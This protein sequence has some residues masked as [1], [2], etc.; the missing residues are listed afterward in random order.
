MSM[1]EDLWAW[2]LIGLIVLIGTTTLWL[3]TARAYG[4][5]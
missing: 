3:P 2:A 4:W 1:N 5:F